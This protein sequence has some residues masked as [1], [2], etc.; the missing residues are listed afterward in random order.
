MQD[1]DASRGRYD[2]HKKIL[3]PQHRQKLAEEIL[4]ATVKGDDRDAEHRLVTL[5]DYEKFDLVKLLLRNRL[6]IV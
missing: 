6:K 2:K 1:I 4:K 3:I 5:L